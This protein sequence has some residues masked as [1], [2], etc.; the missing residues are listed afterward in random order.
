MPR[1]ADPC[2][3]KL[4]IPSCIAVVAHLLA[5]PAAP[6]CNVPVF[7]YALEHWKPSPYLAHVFHRGPLTPAQLAALK[8]LESTPSINLTLTTIDLA[9]PLTKAQ[10]TLWRLHGGDAVLPRV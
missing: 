7:R 8:K 6:A 5:V 10:A 2:R 9:G 3:R 4:A 1:S